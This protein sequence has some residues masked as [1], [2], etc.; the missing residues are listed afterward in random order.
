MLP[1]IRF[2]KA[3]AIFLVL[4]LVISQFIVPNSVSIIQSRDMTIPRHTTAMLWIAKYAS[5]Y[6][7]WLIVPCVLLFIVP[8]QRVNS[9]S[10]FK[11]GER[12]Y[13]IF[14]GAIAFMYVALL[15]FPIWVHILG[16]EK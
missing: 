14:I 13:G 5:Q 4:V 2:S 8:A 7:W 9:L 3:I 10:L 11:S 15:G 12:Y 6:F 1:P 16:G